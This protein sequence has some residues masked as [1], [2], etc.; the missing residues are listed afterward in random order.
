[1]TLKMRGWQLTGAGEPLALVERDV[2]DLAP[3]EVLLAVRGSGLC[4]SDVTELE[5][6][7]VVAF[8]PIIIGHEIAGEIV[9]V[10]SAVTDWTVGMRVAVCPTASETIPGYSRHGG[11]ANY[12]VAPTAS[13]VPIPDAVD[14]SLGAMMTDAGMTSYHALMVR[15]GCKPGMKVGL[16]GFG[17]LGQLAARVA[18]ITGADVHVAEPK[19][20]VWPIAREAGVENIVTDANQWAGQGFDLVVDFAGFDTTRP[21]IRAVRVDG[22]VVQVGLGKDEIILSSSELSQSQ[23]RLYGT[24]GGTPQDIRDLFALVESGQLKPVVTEIGFDDIPAGIADLTAG[25]VTGRLVARM[26]D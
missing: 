21:A 24:M 20:S 9:A 8:K 26:S 4:H 7:T 3:D 5:R 22:T 16:I 12:H 11:F 18:V 17:G 25:R 1:M 13:L 6:A 15:G 23:V 19:E 10:G 14:W 2:P